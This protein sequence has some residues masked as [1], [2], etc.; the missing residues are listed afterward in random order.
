MLTGSSQILFYVC[1]LAVIVTVTGVLAL[2]VI[3]SV[4][5]SWLWMFLYL[6]YL[7]VAVVVF[8]LLK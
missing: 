7:I 2:P 5:Y 6:A 3:M 8:A 1:I 4:V